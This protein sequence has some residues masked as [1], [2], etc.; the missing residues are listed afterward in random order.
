MA[1]FL[2]LY[3]E[4]PSKN[5]ER[6]ALRNTITKASRKKRKKFPYEARHT[7]LALK[8]LLQ[9]G[10]DTETSSVVAIASIRPLSTNGPK[11]NDKEMKWLVKPIDILVLEDV[12]PFFLGKHVF[13]ASVQSSCRARRVSIDN[14]YR[15][16]GS[17]STR[18][19]IF[20][21]ENTDRLNEV[22]SPPFGDPFLQDNVQ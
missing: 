9:R 4:N 14:S 6:T 3:E 16:F 18:G 10:E 11:N 7:G 13:F 20:S 5:L 2:V 19:P 12:F 15:C 1:P 21:S 8:K 22:V 17:V